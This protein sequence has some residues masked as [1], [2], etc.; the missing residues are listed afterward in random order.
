MTF[1]IQ[2]FTICLGL[3][4][5]V[6]AHEHHHPSGPSRIEIFADA[7]RNDFYLQ[8]TA[9]PQEAPVVLMT[10]TETYSL[11]STFWTAS[12]QLLHAIHHL[13]ESTAHA[14]HDCA[15]ALGATRSM[16]RGRKLIQSVTTAAAGLTAWGAQKLR[17]YGLVAAAPVMAFEIA[18]S[19]IGVHFLCAV[20]AVVCLSAS[21]E[22]RDV[23][24]SVRYRYP[25]DR[26]VSERIQKEV[27][28]N[29]TQYRYWHSTR[30]VLSADGTSVLTKGAFRKYLFEDDE[31]GADIFI[32]STFWSS[33]A[34]TM[35][36]QE[37]L[38][39]VGPLDAAVFERPLNLEFSLEKRKFAAE[40]QLRFFELQYQYAEL[41]IAELNGRRTGLFLRLNWIL[42]LQGRVLNEYSRVVRILATKASPTAADRNVLQ[43][44]AAQYLRFLR[45]LAQYLTTVESGGE[46]VGTAFEHRLATEPAQMGK[47]LKAFAKTGQFELPQILGQ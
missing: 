17:R 36:E 16:S 45:D 6:F 37:P 38:Q 44:S 43:G 10:S 34:A 32:D 12:R 14:S 11:D 31:P 4:T 19:A 5:A 29:W 28:S 1:F 22:L 25:A 39:S 3:T 2:T 18:E 41:A 26:H 7:A 42:G 8:K 24:R 21:Q 9:P 33:V 15:A 27:L 46:P 47:T 35:S 30:A 20:G 13:S 40:E 23:W